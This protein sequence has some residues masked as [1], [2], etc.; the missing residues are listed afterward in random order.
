MFITESWFE[1][2]V[3]CSLEKDQFEELN[4]DL[5]LWMLVMRSFN[6]RVVGQATVY[7]MLRRLGEDFEKMRNFQ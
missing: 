1:V 2:W 5:V 7:F 4:V 3:R 6:G